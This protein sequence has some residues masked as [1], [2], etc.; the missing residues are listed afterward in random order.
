MTQPKTQIRKIKSKPLHRTAFFSRESINDETRTAELA[1]S[2][3]EP[4]ERWFGT[5]ILDHAPTSVRLGRLKD[6]GP[7]LVDHDTRDHVGVIESV[8]IDKDR[9]GRAVVRFGKSE[10]A[11]EI[12]QDVVDGI[13]KSVSV[14]YRIHK[15]VLEETGDNQPDV[16]RVN[17]WEPYEVSLVSVPADATV[18]VGR[19]QAD[20]TENEFE[21]TIPK[22]E[23]RT[24]PE[25]KPN[26]P[27]SVDVKVIQENARKEARD[28][29]QLRVREINGLGQ[30]YGLRDLADEFI[31]S[32]KTVD[33]FRA[34]ALERIGTSKPIETESPDIGMSEKEIKRFS[35]LRAINAMAFPNDRKAQQEAAFEREC[36]DAVAAKRGESA[37]GFYV[38]EHGVMGYDKR[39]GKVIENIWHGAK[40]GQR[41]AG[42]SVPSDVLAYRDLLAGTATDGAELVATDL[43]SGSFIDVLRNA[44][45]VRMAGATMLTD[46]VGDVA[47]PRKTSGSAGGWISTEG[48]NAA[49]SDPQ[50]DQVTLSPKTCG[51]YTEVTRQLL[52]QSSLSVENLVRMDLAMGLATTIDLAALYGSG[53]SGQPTGVANTTGINAPTA[54]AAADPTFAEVVALETAVDVDNALMGGLGYITDAAMRGAFK[55]TEKASST[56][57]FIWEPGNTVNG[58]AC[59]ITNQVTDGDV[60]FGNWADLLI[61]MWGGLDILIDPYTNSLSGTVRVVAHQSVD[62]GVRHPVSFAYNNDG[63]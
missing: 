32:D 61:G 56:G 17:D 48:G 51:V 54:F 30:K 4:V 47:I 23:D 44:L 9:R 13:R 16:Y 40:R 19:A 39:T 53:A 35:L 21:L 37:K 57:Q 31:G 59:H 27:A 3:E 14:G 46:L 20:E 25:E 33:E 10:R 12:F 26:T 58:Y 1:F 22:T 28:A 29:E 60:F 45:V 11:N 24:M 43:L 50:F 6:G 62:V 15:A 2:S 7:V 34:A 55:T 8:S 52:K 42:L 49:Q 18:G 63:A 5:E 36:S 41:V 38:P